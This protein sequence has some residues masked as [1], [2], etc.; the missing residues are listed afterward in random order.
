[1]LPPDMLPDA[2]YL[3]RGIPLH[4]ARGALSARMDTILRPTAP[5]ACGFARI[6]GLKRVPVLHPG[7]DDRDGQPSA[8][9]INQGHALAPEHFL[10]GVVP[11]WAAHRNALD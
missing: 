11:P 5:S 7:G 8:I 9:G 1:M 4:W 10:G 2:V 3:I 6:E